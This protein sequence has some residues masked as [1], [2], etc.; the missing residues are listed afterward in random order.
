VRALQE[1]LLLLL[2]L[3]RGQ[4]Y[5]GGLGQPQEAAG[6]AAAEAQ[7]TLQQKTQQEAGAKRRL[8]PDHQLLLLLLLLALP[9]PSG[10]LPCWLPLQTLH[11]HAPTAAAAV[12]HL[13]LHGQL[14]PSH[15]G[16]HPCHQPLLLQLLPRHQCC[17]S[18]A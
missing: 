11:A 14:H 4:V 16:R 9:L 2:L 8:P 7:L 12:R 6:S 1:L 13:Q 17:R 15:D 3:L 5:L 18:V 10:L